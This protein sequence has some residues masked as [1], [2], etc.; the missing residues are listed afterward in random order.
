M[1]TEYGPLV[2]LQAFLFENTRLTKNKL[3]RRA[4]CGNVHCSCHIGRRLCAVWQLGGPFM[5]RT[6]PRQTGHLDGPKMARLK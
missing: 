6:D 5:A 3:Y 4:M 1:I 2:N